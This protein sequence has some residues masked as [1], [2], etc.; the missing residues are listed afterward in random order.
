MAYEAM[1]NAEAAGNRLVVILN[2]NDM[3][4]APPVGSLRNALARLVSSGKYLDSAPAGAEARARDARAAPPLDA[5]DGGI[6]ARLDHRRDALRRAWLLLCR[7][8]RRARCAGAG[9]SAGECPRRRRRADAGPRRDPEGQGLWPRREQRRQISWRGEVRRRFGRP[10]QG[11]RRRAKLSE[12]LRRRRS[13]KLAD[14][15]D[16]IVAITAAMPSGTGVDKFAAA[17][18]TAPSTSALPNSMR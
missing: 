3:S 5:Q 18:P 15:D 6:Y 1:N 2:D 7:A 8:D 9:R 12:C 10:G 4:I 17:S 16:K 14:S 11:R 13:A